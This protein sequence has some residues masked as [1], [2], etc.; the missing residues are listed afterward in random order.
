MLIFEKNGA[1]QLMHSSNITEILNTYPNNLRP[2]VVVLNSCHSEN[3]GRAFLNG[4]VSHVICCSKAEMLDDQGCIIFSEIFYKFL[5]DPNKP[6][7]DSMDVCTAFKRA[8]EGVNEH[9]GKGEATK[10]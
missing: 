3:I 9:I 4:G 5:L 1:T 2:Y 8:L 10:Y 7:K 6:E